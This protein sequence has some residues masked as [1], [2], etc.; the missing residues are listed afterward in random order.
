MGEVVRQ[1]DGARPVLVRAG[2][3]SE[4]ARPHIPVFAPL[5][6]IRSN[7]RIRE[8]MNER[9]DSRGEFVRREWLRHEPFE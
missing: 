3:P 1:A 8:P 6:W 7:P 5:R 9:Y 4:C 2:T